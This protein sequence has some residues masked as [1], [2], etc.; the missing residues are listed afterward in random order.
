MVTA[1]TNTAQELETSYLEVAALY[2]S[3]DELISTV[4][5]ASG[6]DKAAHFHLVNQLVEQLEESA[7]VLS[8]EFI[9]IAE[10]TSKGKAISGS[11]KNR[12]EAAF[13]KIYAAL[14]L[15]KTR[16]QDARKQAFDHIAD[17]VDPVVER[18]KRQV[19][20]VIS[21]FIGFVELSLDR[22]MQKSDLELLKQHE[23][24]IANILHQLSQNGPRP[25]T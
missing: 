7:D 17:V 18:V 10:R 24:K 1:M 11:G 15:Y 5:K 6:E 16:S 23:T 3:A 19:E 25:T 9:S 22:I 12:I 14:D 4:E 21:V 2:D 20:R 13:R 8:E